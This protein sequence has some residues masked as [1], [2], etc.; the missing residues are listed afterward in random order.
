MKTDIKNKIT[1]K[2]GLELM[3]LKDKGVH[4]ITAEFSGSGDDGAIDDIQLY[5][6]EDCDYKSN[7]GNVM[8]DLPGIEQI[9]VDIH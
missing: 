1:L 3:Y 4:T 7:V 5:D 2:E 8:A 9:I 6:T